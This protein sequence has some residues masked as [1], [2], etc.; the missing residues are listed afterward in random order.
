MYR[1]ASIRRARQVRESPQSRSPSPSSSAAR[2]SDARETLERLFCAQP[3]D[4]HNEDLLEETILAAA[5]PQAQQDDLRTAFF[6]K[7]QAQVGEK[8]KDECLREWQEFDSGPCPVVSCRSPSPLPPIPSS[9][10]S[11]GRTSTDTNRSEDQ[12]DD[13]RDSSPLSDIYPG[14][15]KPDVQAPRLEFLSSS[16]AVPVPS[17]PATRD[18]DLVSSPTSAPRGRN[19]LRGPSVSPIPS[20]A[21]SRNALRGSGVEHV[22]RA[23]RRMSEVDLGVQPR[24][25]RACIRPPVVDLVTL[26]DSAD[27]PD[28][29]P[30]PKRGKGKGKGKAKAKAKTPIN[31]ILSEDEPVEVRRLN[32][33][34]GK[35]IAP[36]P[37]SA[38]DMYEP[39]IDVPVSEDD[40]FEP[41]RSLG[42]AAVEPLS[43]DS[44]VPARS[45]RARSQSPVV[46][47]PRARVEFAPLVFEPDQARQSG[48][49]HPGLR[50]LK[51]L[52]RQSR[53]EAWEY[54]YFPAPGY[55]TKIRVPSGATTVFN[56][57]NL[58]LH[59][60][61]PQMLKTA[62]EMRRDAFPDEDNSWMD[63]FSPVDL[64]RVAIDGMTPK[65]VELMS[66]GRPWTHDE[67]FSSLR[68]MECAKFKHGL[69]DAR[70]VQLD[71]VQ[72]D[73]T[74]ELLRLL[75]HNYVGSSAS[76]SNYM[77]LSR[78]VSHF[79]WYLHRALSNKALY[80]LMNSPNTRAELKALLLMSTKIREEYGTL[81]VK[82]LEACFI[83]LTGSWLNNSSLAFDSERGHWQKMKGD[84]INL[85]PE[86]WLECYKAYADPSAQTCRDM[87]KSALQSH[88]LNNSSPMFEDHMLSDRRYLRVIDGVELYLRYDPDR[89]AFRIKMAS[90]LVIEIGTTQ[91]AEIVAIGFKPSSKGKEDGT[92]ATLQLSLTAEDD[93]RHWANLSD[94]RP[95]YETAR[96][97]MLTLSWVSTKTGE[98][99]VYHVIRC[100]QRTSKLLRAREAMSLLEYANG[101]LTVGVDSGPKRADFGCHDVDKAKNLDDGDGVACPG[102]N[103]SFV[104]RTNRKK[105]VHWGKSPAC[106]TAYSRLSS[107]EKQDFRFFICRNCEKIFDRLK[108]VENHLRENKQ[109]GD[110]P[111]CRAYFQELHGDEIKP[112]RETSAR[113]L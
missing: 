3:K 1:A 107:A 68:D 62:Y 38:D 55:F 78:G 102:P 105:E 18:L 99:V 9:P 23:Q 8:D 98:V 43:E 25:K 94:A 41:A 100:K 48:R 15:P 19:A 91:A 30:R 53:T 64:A 29:S 85:L 73:P 4:S 88:G 113:F 75:L 71:P 11:H 106:K 31:D 101:T 58:S 92:L 36:E 89:L 86:A 81:P 16:P 70:V 22:G 76:T 82:L 45:S 108:S 74:A 103:C 95:E 27:E 2:R 67:W 32:K 56:P 87:M 104:H 44:D 5:T 61:L 72:P 90:T 93:E 66:Q 80:I 79:E 24:V 52:T 46:V 69:Y 26:D 35:A 50:N 7:Y 33:G 14:S 28:Q 110:E 77:L 57:G 60:V 17:I 84:K 34:K 51:D 112:T 37:E 40:E 59:S 47:A 12:L 10:Q 42:K 111:E 65:S 49:K 54:E 13:T 63:V 97:I 83:D 109:F 6:S 96:R 20:L 39:E 21:P